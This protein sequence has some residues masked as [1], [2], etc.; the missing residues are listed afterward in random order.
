M[1]AVKEVAL[2]I[3]AGNKAVLFLFALSDDHS[4]HDKSFAP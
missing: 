3:F 2:A 1:I 4:L